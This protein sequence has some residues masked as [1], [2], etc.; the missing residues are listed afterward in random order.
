MES[1]NSVTQWVMENEPMLARIFTVVTVSYMVALFVYKQGGRLINGST[2]E[3]DELFQFLKG[4]LASS[5]GWNRPDN[6]TIKYLATPGC[7]RP[8]I[9][10]AWDAKNCL[11]YL[12]NDPIHS[13]GRLAGWQLKRISK[14]GK[15]VAATLDAQA[16]AGD[17]NRLLAS[18]QT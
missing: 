14:S 13:N 6:R 3:Q 12:G 7:T 2:K 8:E 11:V 17:I 10:V 18:L 1:F 5:N 15:K 9:K 16:R 4:L